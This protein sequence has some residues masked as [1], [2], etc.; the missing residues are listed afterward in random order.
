[1]IFFNSKG[2]MNKRIQSISTFSDPSSVLWTAHHE[3]DSNT[4]FWALS[5][6]VSLY[7]VRGMSKCSSLIQRKILILWLNTSSR[8]ASSVVEGE[9]VLH[10]MC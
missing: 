2:A 5:R 8:S 4:P 7:G 10:N 9:N 6:Y 3:C 1:L